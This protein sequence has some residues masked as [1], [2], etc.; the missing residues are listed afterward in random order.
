MSRVRVLQYLQSMRD[1]RTHCLIMYK[2]F[3]TAE[4]TKEKKFAAFNF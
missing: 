4:S 3:L 1:G 2:I